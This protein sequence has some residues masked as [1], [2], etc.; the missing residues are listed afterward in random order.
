[1]PIFRNDDVSADTNV[2]HFCEF[3]KIFHKYGYTQIHA[4]VLYG[5]TNCNYLTGDE[6][7]PS[8]YL[9]EKNLSAIYNKRITDLSKNKFIGNNKALIDYLN[10]IPD[11]IALHGLF[12]TNYSKMTYEEQKRDILQGLKLLNELFPNKKV[13]LFIP[14]FNKANDD[15][16]K[17]CKELNL[18]ISLDEEGSDYHLEKLIAT[19]SYKLENNHV[20]RYH[21]HRFYPESTFWYY[22][23]TLHYLDQFFAISNNKYVLPKICLLCDRRDW[24]HD[25]NAREIKH[26]LSYDFDIDIKYVVDSPILNPND[27]DLLHVFFWG[28]EAYKKFKFP[29]YKII[30]QVSSHRWQDNP[31]YGPLSTEQFVNKYLS[32]SKFVTCPSKILYDLLKEHVNNLFLIKKGYSSLKFYYKNARSGDLNICWAGNIKDPVKG[33]NEILIPSTHNR[34]NLNLASDLKHN[35]LLDFYNSND[36][37]VVCSRNEADPLPLIE[38]MACGCFPVANYVG[39]APELIQHKK[40]GFL[41]KDRTVKAYQEAFDWCR[42]HLDY[43]RSVSSKISEDI[44]EI[45]RWAVTSEEYK[46]MYLRCL[47][48]NKLDNE[49]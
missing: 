36:V 9:G 43:I 8:P 48:L 11:E 47:E 21:H 5:Y 28:E 6:R 1:M 19:H 20:Y 22:D 46:K 29:R 16:F 30:K 23:L 35:E 12:H 13:S 4:V 27:Y 3:C 10:I 32:D 40:N 24:A 31:L 42:D 2:E 18:Q 45:R 25:H 49:L 14:P 34:F 26:F 41:V 39:I 15:T 44:F 37:F 38:A 7:C 33:V 17:I